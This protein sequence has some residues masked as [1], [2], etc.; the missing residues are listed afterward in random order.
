MNPVGWFQAGGGKISSFDLTEP[1]MQSTIKS[2]IKRCAKIS[3]T[4]VILDCHPRLN[5]CTVRP[6]CIDTS[7]NKEE[8]SRR[9]IF[10]EDVPSGRFFEI[11]CGDGK[12][13]YLLGIRGNLTYEEPFYLTNKVRFDRK[14]QYVGL[15]LLAR[16]EENV[17]GGDICSP[18][19]VAMHP[20]L[21]G[22]CAVVYSNNVFEHLRHP[23]AAARAVSM[24]LQPRG[25]CITVVPFSQRYHEAPED[26]F[27]YTHK[28]LEALFSERM[29]IEVLR[30]GYDIL[31]RRNDWQGSGERNDAVPT[32]EF[33]AW[34]ETWFA[35][36]AFRKIAE[37]T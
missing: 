15:D 14:F 36:L 8:E 22:G 3:R 34:R 6:P 27:R 32:D 9:I 10:L 18:E 16:P 12:L 17:I 26:Y 35:F 24:L 13:G 20:E 5:A 25:V 28:G 4:R 30:S 1:L 23:W 29:K 11:G 31:G 19:F 37:A 33:G 21:A 7:I 2:L